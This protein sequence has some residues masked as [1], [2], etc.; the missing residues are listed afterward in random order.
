MY[1]DPDVMEAIRKAA[2]GPLGAR[3]RSV[4]LS[5]FDYASLKSTIDPGGVVN[6]VWQLTFELIGWAG[7]QGARCITKAEAM[8]AGPAVLASL[9]PRFLLACRGDGGPRY[10]AIFDGSYPTAED[11]LT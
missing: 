9:S 7:S 8:S 6:G 11:L 2:E 4:D 10:Q 5:T 1:S 3:E